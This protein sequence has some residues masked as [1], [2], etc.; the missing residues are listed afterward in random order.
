MLHY[1]AIKRQNILIYF[2]REKIIGGG[3]LCI[4]TVR[5][6]RAD[7][8]LGSSQHENAEHEEKTQE[9][10]VSES[11]GSSRSSFH[12]HLTC[13]LMTLQ[14]M[15]QVST[16]RLLKDV[17]SNQKVKATELNHTEDK[18]E[19]HQ[20]IKIEKLQRMTF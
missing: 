3:G 12:A 1:I 20:V 5:K 7:R 2:L 19:E 13:F 8:N 17:S 15:L 10:I 6:D 14:S 4:L 9:T 11:E 18:D 16:Q